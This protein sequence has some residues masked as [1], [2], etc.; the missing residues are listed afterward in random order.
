MEDQVKMEI[1][2]E[3]QLGQGRNHENY[4][5]GHFRGPPPG[6]NG[7][8]AHYPPHTQSGQYPGYHGQQGPQQGSDG[9]SGEQ[10]GP[11][12]HNNKCAN[13]KCRNYIPGH[14]DYCTS[15]CV[16]GECKEVYD[17]WSSC[18]VKPGANTPGQGPNPDVM[19]K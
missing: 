11:R 9:G 1:K 15:E 13:Y 19:V 3:D 7:P 8:G 4:E 12:Q 5:N 14:S 2:M 18:M 16:V 10:T 17:N 6:T